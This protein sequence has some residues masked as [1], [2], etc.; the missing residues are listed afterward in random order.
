MGGSDFAPAIRRNAPRFN[1]VL[2]RLG[3]AST[4]PYYQD[5]PYYQHCPY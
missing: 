2:A 3:T 4:A 1:L 5:S